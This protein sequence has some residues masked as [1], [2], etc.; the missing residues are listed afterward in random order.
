MK[1]CITMR[2]L[3]CIIDLSFERKDSL[4][5]VYDAVSIHQ[6][7]S[8]GIVRFAELDEL[9]AFKKKTVGLMGLK[10]VPGLRLE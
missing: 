4:G 1:G 6:T 2:M 10:G 3:P 9:P 5:K 8:V 7:S